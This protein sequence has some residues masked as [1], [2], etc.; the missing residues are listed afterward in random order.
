VE[1]VALDEAG[2]RLSGATGEVTLSVDGT[3]PLL[4]D[5]SVAFQ[6]G[7]AHFGGLRIPE[8]GAGNTLVAE[9]ANLA[10][11]TSQPFDIVQGQPSTPAAVDGGIA[12]R[13]FGQVTEADSNGNFL[14]AWT[15]FRGDDTQLEVRVRRFAPDGTPLGAAFPVATGF[16]DNNPALACGP[17]GSFVISWTRSTDGNATTRIFARRYDAADQPSGPELA[18]SPGQFDYESHSA[19]VVHPDGGFA[20]AWTGVT[21]PSPASA[22]ARTLSADGAPTQAAFPVNATPQAVSVGVDVAG[23]AQGGFTVVWDV[24][25]QS[26]VGRRFAPD[27]TPRGGELL[28]L[29][30]HEL[31]EGP[32]IAMTPSGSFVVVY[33]T[34]DLGRHVVSARL[35]DTAGQ[36]KGDELDLSAAGD[37][38]IEPSVTISDDGWFVAAWTVAG[39]GFPDTS[40]LRRYRPDGTPDGPTAALTTGAD[41]DYVPEVAI[42]ANGVVAAVWE[43][44]QDDP[45]ADIQSHVTLQIFHFATP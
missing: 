36:P 23:D 10:S 34:T 26:V 43:G 1:V 31:Q 40:L 9:S 17:D 44:V 6:D 19:V 22:W 35:F 20:I 21:N 37:L 14:V 8:A 4:G 41:A 5:T 45:P 16:L 3:G 39:L 29:S 38:A 12:G 28:L 27:G 30:G 2:Q 25:G 7:V 13:Q 24:E 33:N 11:A 18:V 15:Q 42:N 32:R